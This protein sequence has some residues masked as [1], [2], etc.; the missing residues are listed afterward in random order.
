[1][2]TSTGLSVEYVTLDHNVQN[3]I[4][5][6]NFIGSS[7]RENGWFLWSSDANRTIRRIGEGG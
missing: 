6:S 2:T 1:M 3:A 5:Y 7:D 4:S